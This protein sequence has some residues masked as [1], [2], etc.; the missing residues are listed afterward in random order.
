MVLERLFFYLAISTLK[1]CG[2][3]AIFLYTQLDCRRETLKH[4]NSYCQPEIKLKVNMEEKN[5]LQP[6]GSP[7]DVVKGLFVG[8]IYFSQLET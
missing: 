4:S 2:G 3:Q 1:Q 6:A 8:E 5:I 7:K